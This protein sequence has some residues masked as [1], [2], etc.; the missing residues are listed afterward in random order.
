MWVQNFEE[1]GDMVK[2]RGGSAKCVC[3]LEN[4]ARVEEAFSRS[5]RRSARKHALQLDISDRS[6]RRILHKELQ[7]HPYKMQIMQKLNANDLPKRLRFCWELL[8]L[9]K[10]TQ[11]HPGTE[12]S[13]LGGS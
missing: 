12:G 2:K 11:H 5:P 4:V 10:E 9:M 6:V 3:T 7:Y 8:E 13:N 1:T